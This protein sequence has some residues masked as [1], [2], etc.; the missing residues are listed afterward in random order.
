MTNLKLYNIHTV[1][2]CWTGLTFGTTQFRVKVMIHYVVINTFRM[3]SRPLGR[4]LC[5]EMA[6][7]NTLVA[8]AS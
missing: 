5:E 1:L 7:L 4:W 8:K 6:R 3:N 2:Y